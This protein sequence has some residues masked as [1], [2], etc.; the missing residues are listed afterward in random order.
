VFLMNLAR[1]TSYSEYLCMFRSLSWRHDHQSQSF[2]TFE[3]MGTV[4]LYLYVL[5]YFQI[6]FCQISSE[7]LL[8]I[9][10]RARVSTLTQGIKIRGGSDMSIGFSQGLEARVN[11]LLEDSP[12]NENTSVYYRCSP[13]VTSAAPSISTKISVSERLAQAASDGNKADSRRKNK[14]AKSWE[15]LE[16]EIDHLNCSGSSLI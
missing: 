4:N 12:G 5:V 11:Y 6:L 8:F 16:Q 14:P 3:L 9:S 13:S 2:L 1:F 15:E 10:F 7:F